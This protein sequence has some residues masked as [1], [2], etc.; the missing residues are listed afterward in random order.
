[1]GFALENA[2]EL[3]PTEEEAVRLIPAVLAKLMLDLKIADLAEAFAKAEDPNVFLAKIMHDTAV[4]RY[5]KSK[6]NL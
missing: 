1:M 2:R 6:R 3:A 4:R 5:L